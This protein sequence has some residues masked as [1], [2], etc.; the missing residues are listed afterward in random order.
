M[1]HL[2]EHLIKKI[3]H[4]SNEVKEEFRKKG[5]AIPTMND[6]GSISLGHYT[7]KKGTDGF[8]NILDYSGEAVVSQLNLAQTAAIVANNLALGKFVDDELVNKDRR[9][10]YAVFEEEQAKRALAKSSKKDLDYFDLMLTK[11]MIA[12]AKKNLY[13][14]EIVKS[15]EKL[16]NLV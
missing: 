14:S 5:I 15:F 13:K 16:R 12:K 9:Y 4:V 6:N 2:P 10:G 11:H 8:Y 7:I 3:L 1:D